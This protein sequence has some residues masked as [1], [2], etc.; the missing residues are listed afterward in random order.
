MP[1]FRPWEKKLPVH[2][3]TQEEPL[4]NMGT[5]RIMGSKKD[6][7]KVEYDINES[8]KSPERRHAEAEVRK[9]RTR[10]MNLHDTAKAE[11]K[12]KQRAKALVKEAKAAQ[13][14]RAHAPKGN[15]KYPAGQI[16]RAEADAH[17]WERTK[18]NSEVVDRSQRRLS[19]GLAYLTFKT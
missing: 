12:A 1:F 9:M 18:K 5:L 16:K 10:S 4:E 3:R 7:G 17:E 2:K 11:A 8:L 19:R 13:I 14:T 15:F 6:L